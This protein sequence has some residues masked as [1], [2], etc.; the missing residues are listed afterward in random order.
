MEL[1][2]LYFLLLLQLLLCVDKFELMQSYANAI[3]SSFEDP[4]KI[5]EQAVLDMNNDLIKV[6]QA[7]AQVCNEF[8]CFIHIY[9]LCP[10]FP[11]WSI[12][13]FT[14]G[15]GFTFIQFVKKGHC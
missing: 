10:F 9:S 15:L 4:E 3:I 2:F 8:F 6:R 11:E 1:I 5:L 12:F 14:S 13:Y 7:T